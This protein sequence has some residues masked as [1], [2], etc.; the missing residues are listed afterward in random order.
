MRWLIALGVLGACHRVFGVTPSSNDALT[1]ACYG[2]FVTVCTEDSPIERMITADTT[3]ETSGGSECATLSRGPDVCLVLATT[4]DISSGATVRGAGARPLVVVATQTL[5]IAGTLTVASYASDDAGA[6]S[7]GA[8]CSSGTAPSAADGVGAGGAGGSFV[9]M[10]GIGRRGR[11]TDDTLPG[12]ESRPGPPQPLLAELRGGCAG[13]SGAGT[14]SAPGGDGGGAIA[15][16]SPIISVAGRLDAS[17]SPGAGGAT[18]R[19]GGGGG[20]SGGMIVLDAA[21]ISVTG[22]VL[23]NG[24]AGGEGATG[25]SNGEDGKLSPDWASEPDGGNRHIGG[26]GGDGAFLSFE[27]EDGRSPSGANDGGP[28]HA[29]GGGGGGGAGLVHVVPYAPVPSTTPPPMPAP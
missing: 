27:A 26:N 17:G 20:G 11:L 6:G 14:T 21:T 9:T 8:P 13:I 5:S 16:I 22:S 10:G 23:A 7:G 24:G 3:L 2:T 4:F 28:H 15:L 12:S 18:S 1:E 19:N 25:S 29:G